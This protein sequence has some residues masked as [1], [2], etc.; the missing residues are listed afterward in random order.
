MLF[1]LRA[2]FCCLEFYLFMLF[3][4][5]FKAP[6][7][8]FFRSKC[9]KRVD[10]WTAVQFHARLKPRLLHRML[11][12]Y[13]SRISRLLEKESSL[14]D[15]KEL[16]WISFS[17]TFRPEGEKVYQIF[18]GF[19]SGVYDTRILTNRGIHFRRFPPA[20]SNARYS[21]GYFDRRKVDFMVRQR[22]IVV[23]FESRRFDFFSFPSFIFLS[24]VSFFPLFFRAPAFSRSCSKSGF[25]RK[26]N[27]REIIC[28]RFI[29]FYEQNL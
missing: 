27:L 11:G 4:F 22:T 23:A 2:F 21:A 3:V 24:L 7:R 29:F 10:G 13:Y 17:A 6:I 26:R 8:G 15:D 20:D 5:F 12:I 1:V 14:S 25:I 28:M 9:E 16:F 19:V 18:V